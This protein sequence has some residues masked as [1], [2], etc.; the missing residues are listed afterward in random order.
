MVP[1]Y[2]VLCC[3]DPVATSLLLLSDA[4]RGGFIGGLPGMGNRPCRP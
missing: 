4:S 1:T 2:R 3:L